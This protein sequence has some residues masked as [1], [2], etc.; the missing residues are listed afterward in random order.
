MSQ[1]LAQMDHLRRGIH[2]RGY[3]QKQPEQEY[4]RESFDLFKLMIAATQSEVAQDLS[5]VH[6]PTQE[7]LAALEAQRQAQTL[8]PSDLDYIHEES[9]G[10]GGQTRNDPELAARNAQA[11]AAEGL[12]LGAK[13]ASNPYA[14]QK[15][16][17]NAPCPCG[18]GKKYKNC[19]GKAL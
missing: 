12:R 2:L 4:K 10:L 18:S 9:D 5:Q 8:A 16:S 1:A 6:I 19:H 14:N 17:R 11:H 3:A 13:T 15:V 7:E